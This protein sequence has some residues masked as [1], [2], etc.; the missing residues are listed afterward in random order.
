MALLA[1]YAAGLGIPF[2]VAAFFTDHFAR[3]TRRLR[4]WG[5]WVHRGSGVVLIIVG[6]AMMTGQLTRFAY[7]LLETFPILG[8]IG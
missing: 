7:W 3:S 2:L 6:A 5:A 1:T 4:R 8:R